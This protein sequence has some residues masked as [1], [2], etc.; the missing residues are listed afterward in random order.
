MIR[1]QAILATILTAA[2][3][4]G[5]HRTPPE[6]E[7]P[8]NSYLY[9]FRMDGGLF[10]SDQQRVLLTGQLGDVP[11]VFVFDIR[12][13][14]ATPVTS[15]KQP[16][17]PISYLPGDGRFM[18]STHPEGESV[19]HLFMHSTQGPDTD[20]TPWPGVQAVFYAWTQNPGSFYFGSNKDDRRFLHIYRMNVAEKTP[21]LVLETQDMRFTASSM[22]GR[23]LALWRRLSA[24]KSAVWV[25]DFLSKSLDKVAPGRDDAIAVPQF[26]DSADSLYYLTNE[27]KPVLSLAKYDFQKKTHTTVYSAGQPIIFARQSPNQ[28]YVVLGVQQGDRVVS[29]LFDVSGDI[30]NEMPLAQPGLIVDLS[31]DGKSMLYNT[32]AENDS[33]N[34]QLYNLETK[35]VRRIHPS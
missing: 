9:K 31:P 10:S 7:D 20:L 22:T 17:Y 12:S 19:A 8:I 30:W 27:D 24:G 18:Y 28:R 15:S 4:I 23:Y 32:G 29:R 34:L 21:T 3:S 35:E 11:N 13:N 16:A 14:S 33:K 1:R 2:L 5:C 25:Y 26:F 6:P